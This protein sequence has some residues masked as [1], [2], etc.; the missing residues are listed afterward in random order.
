L[1]EVLSEALG[2]PLEAISDQI[3]SAYRIPSEV[4]GAIQEYHEFFLAQRPKEPGRAARRLDIAH[5]L[6]VAVGRPGTK[7]AQVRPIHPD[8][9]APLLAT[10]LLRCEDDH[11]LGLQETESGLEEV[12]PEVPRISVPISLWRDPRWVAPDPVE[13]VLSL[14]ADC[15]LVDR[16]EQIGTGGR[17]AL[18]M[19]EP[20]TAE[21]DKLD[22]VGSVL[23]LHR[24]TLPVGSV[25]TGVE[26][27]RLPISLALLSR[28][29][30]KRP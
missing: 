9:L 14:M 24:G 20:G 10:D 6:A 30:G 1:H 8:E 29:L 12:E 25:P 15:M 5:H 3:L 22:S 16:I 13:S 23:V 4:A 27:H 17:T 26:F 18:A 7:F 2:C 21:W 19:V 28:R 11:E